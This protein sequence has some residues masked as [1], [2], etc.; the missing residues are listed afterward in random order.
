MNDVPSTSPDTVGAGAP[1]DGIEITPAMVEAGVEEYSRVLH[2]MDSFEEIVTMIYKAMRA[3]KVQT[4][5]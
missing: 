1:E 2:D 5:V 3:V 4:K